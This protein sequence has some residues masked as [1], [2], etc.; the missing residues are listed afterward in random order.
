MGEHEGSL[1]PRRWGRGS[2]RV[3]H[4]FP[5]S[6]QR[7]DG[8]GNGKVEE[9]SNEDLSA[10]P[11]AKPLTKSEILEAWHSRMVPLGFPAVA[12]MTGQRE[13]QLRAG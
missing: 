3:T 8:G 12:K 1:N 6:R 5:K 2:E 9:S 7:K 11:T 13:R 4:W 10:E